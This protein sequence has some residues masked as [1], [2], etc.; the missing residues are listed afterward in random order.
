MLPVLFPQAEQQVALARVRYVQR[1][2]RDIVHNVLEVGD[3]I[4]DV[5]EFPPGVDHAQYVM[6]QWRQLEEQDQREN[7]RNRGIGGGYR[8]G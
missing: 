2:L 3:V 4:P 6:R 5:E 1:I 8:G 7:A